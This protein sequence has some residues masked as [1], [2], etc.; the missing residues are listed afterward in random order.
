MPRSAPEKRTSPRTHARKAASRPATSTVRVLFVPVWRRSRRRVG[1]VR[2]SIVTSERAECFA[3]ACVAMR[4]PFVRPFKLL[5]P[6]ETT[7]AKLKEVA[8]LVEFERGGPPLDHARIFFG[9]P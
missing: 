1:G 9:H 4:I 8:G 7:G 3:S 6:G 5:R 2:V